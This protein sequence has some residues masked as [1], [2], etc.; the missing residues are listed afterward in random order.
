VPVGGLINALQNHS[1][2]KCF[3]NSF[4]LKCLL[5]LIEVILYTSDK[6]YEPYGIAANNPELESRRIYFTP[7]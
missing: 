6:T 2:A 4:S 1:A 7:F 3:K 5:E